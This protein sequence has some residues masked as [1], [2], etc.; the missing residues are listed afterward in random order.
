M[1][2]GEEEIR[3]Y[4]VVGV[5]LG[6]GQRYADYFLSSGPGE[7]EEMAHQEIEEIGGGLLVAA[8]ILD[9]QIVS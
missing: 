7:A 2:K 9:G 5:D 3:N 6:N 8:V 4:L 1:L